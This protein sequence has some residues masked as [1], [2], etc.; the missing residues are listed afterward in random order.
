MKKHKEVE[1]KQVRQSMKMEL[2]METSRIIGVLAL[3]KV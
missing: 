1:S 2:G 3:P